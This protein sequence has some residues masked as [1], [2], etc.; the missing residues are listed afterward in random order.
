MLKPDDCQV[1][2]DNVN[3]R[4]LFRHTKMQCDRRSVSWSQRG[5]EEAV[6]LSLRIMWEWE[7]DVRGGDCP[8]PSEWVGDMFDEGR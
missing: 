8:L 7:L 5:M 4:F 2:I 1:I 3:G 6:R